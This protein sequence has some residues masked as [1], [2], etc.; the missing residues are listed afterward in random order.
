MDAD[1]HWLKSVDGYLTCLRQLPVPLELLVVASRRVVREGQV[2]RDVDPRL[3]DDGRVT[4]G[5]A[6]PFRGE[7]GDLI[8]NSRTSNTLLDFCL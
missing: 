6:Q 7:N 8:G 4:W 5:D 2:G 3:R 1:L